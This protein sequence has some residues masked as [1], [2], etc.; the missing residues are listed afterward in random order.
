[1]ATIFM[2]HHRDALDRQF[3]VGMLE[4]LRELADVRSNPLP[5]PL[6]CAE[7][8]E[9]AA[10][11]EIVI[12]D[13]A[14]AAPREVF[15]RLPDLV[16]FERVAVD[17]RNVDIEAASR[18]GVLVTHA[19]PGFD[20]AV[21]EWVLGVMIDLARDITASVIDYRA[22]RAPAMR[23][24]RQLRGSRLGVIGYGTIGRYLADA[25]LALGM[26]LMVADPY[27]RPVDSR[28]R[29]VPLD[30]LLA[31]ADFVVCLAVANAETENLMNARTFGLM[32]PSAY[33]INGAR[34]NLVDETALLDA[35]AARRIA[36][37]AMDVGRAADQMPIRTLAAR[38]DVIA[39]PH[40]AGHTPEAIAHQA[41][42]AIAQARL[43]LRGQVPDGALNA[44]AASRLRRFSDLDPTA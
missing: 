18:A 37:A 35:L 39:T 12:S 43:I 19:S 7:L 2:T 21:S 10:G 30:A 36:G 38:P 8:V 31:D 13:R 28:I 27:A 6:A 9:H 22:A 41:R 14:T 4:A 15:E 40:I 25:G 23:V 3:G 34:G 20:A 16:A 5:R 1:M 11:C 17:V 26:E 42:D 33:F 44:S 32:K 24:G 29:H